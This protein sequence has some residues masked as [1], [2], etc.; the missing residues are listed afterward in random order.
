MCVLVIGMSLQVQAAESVRILDW[1]LNGTQ[2]ADVTV[3]PGERISGNVRMRTSSSQL[4]G[5]HLGAWMPSWDTGSDNI[6]VFTQT[7]F[8]G[9]MDVNVSVEATAPT[10]EGVYHLLFA[11]GE[12]K[13]DEIRRDLINLSYQN[14]PPADQSIRIVVD[15]D[16]VRVVDRAGAGRSKEEA[17]SILVGGKDVEARAGH[18][19]GE[20][21]W[22]KVNTGNLA[23]SKGDVLRVALDV[24]DAA[25]LDLEILDAN[26]QRR[27][28]SAAEGALDELSFVKVRASEILYVHVY[29][30]QPHEEAAFKLS[31]SRASLSKFRQDPSNGE[32]EAISYDTR[33]SGQAGADWKSSAWYKIARPANEELSLR[34]E[35]S[36]HGA[37]LDL[38]VYDD[39]GNELAKSR[40]SGSSNERLKLE[41]LFGGEYYIRVGAFRPS[42][43]SD[44]T[45]TV[46][47]PTAAPVVV[48][49]QSGAKKPL[50]I[51]A[52]VQKDSPLVGYLNVQSE[53]SFLVELFTGWGNFGEIDTVILTAPDGTVLWSIKAD[54]RG[55]EAARINSRGSGF[56]RL[57]IRTHHDI[58]RRVR[59]QVDNLIDQNFYPHTPGRG[60]Y[61]PVGAGLDSE[62]QATLHR[63]YE[64]MFVR[65][66]EGIDSEERQL[67]DQLEVYFREN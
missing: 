65:S 3:A 38:W 54:G 51:L 18:G 35:G 66:G 12:K 61:N 53:N 63:V 29:A 39:L 50:P 60:E 33:V 31:V 32:A 16:A 1:N 4:L 10:S 20:G 44:F 19:E 9:S 42:D 22:A 41:E 30:Y 23:S 26:G 37:D 67:L 48:D 49:T 14:P 25:D 11:F 43:A 21:F 45:L 2:T 28:F 17:V 55:W 64:M 58:P 46:G 34:L 15:R 13:E 8:G 40:E 36:R 7:F 62:E 56:Y 27:G 6:H 59:L 24:E 5:F 47:H 57:E 52:E